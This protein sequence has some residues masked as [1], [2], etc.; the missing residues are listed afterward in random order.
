MQQ[1]L[2]QQQ[3]HTVPSVA[4]QPS[5][6]R[7]SQDNGYVNQ[8]PAAAPPQQMPSAAE[9]AMMQMQQ[10][11]PQA[12]PGFG[13]T[14]ALSRPMTIGGS[15]LSLLAR[16]LTASPDGGA[17]LPAAP[18]PLSNQDIP[19]ADA[20]LPVQ[21]PDG[22]RNQAA[23][24]LLIQQ[25]LSRAQGISM[26]PRSSGGLKKFMM[27]ALLLL[28]AAGATLWIMRD[29]LGLVPKN[30]DPGPVEP[31]ITRESK[32]GPEPGVDPIP[33]TKKEREEEPRVATVRAPDPIEPKITPSPAPTPEPEPVVKTPTPPKA[34]PVEEETP[35]PRAVPVEEGTLKPM[36]AQTPSPDQGGLVEVGR[37]KDDPKV[38]PGSASSTLAESVE[39]PIVK[40]VPP[41]CQKAL[42]GLK[43]FLGAH[44]LKERL[45]YMQMAS[46]IERKAAIYY[47]SNPDGPVDVD[48]IHYLR[49]DEDPQV[50][51]GMHVV[52]VIFSRAW[53]YGIPVMVEQTG[54]NTRIDWLSFVEFK[55]DLLHKFLT[56][57]M[58]GPVRFHVGIRRTHYFEDDIPNVEEKDTFEVTTPMENVHGFVFVPRGSPLQRSLS[59]T[60]SWDKEMSWVIVELQWRRQGSSKWVE[61]TALPQL[62]WY[63]AGGDDAPEST[64]APSSALTK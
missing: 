61:M 38:I 49:H 31:T 25:Q 62:N 19:G 13:A 2:Y 58:D 3:S 47:T 53:E 64:S 33:R 8:G 24:N 29:Q 27:A 51:K 43:K 48:E 28:C 4:M 5:L 20:P 46:Q 56:T 50:G 1:G 57:Y 36:V 52:F 9:A 32:R 55:D 42:D 15:R 23:A 16:Q 18:P 10:P 26:T 54:D 60:I 12:D 41:K 6:L 35:V 59:S 30:L 39:K 17:G 44:T 63:S 11:A 7:P 45:P 37:T 22:L 40:N 21:M 34:Q 14:S